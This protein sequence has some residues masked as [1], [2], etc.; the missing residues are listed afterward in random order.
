MPVTPNQ[1]YQK[2][3]ELPPLPLAMQKLCSIAGNTEVDADELVRVISMD[4][5]LTTK[6]LRVANSGHYGMGRESVTV[7]DVLMVL[8][9]KEIQ[10]VAIAMTLID[11]K[12]GV[13]GNCRLKRECLWQ[14]S[15]AVAS[16]MRLIAPL[17]GL[18]NPDEL[19]V[20]GLLHDIGKIIFSDYFAGQYNEVLER[21]AMGQRTLKAA[22]REAFGI[23]YAA[24]GHEVCCHWKLP[25][26]IRKMVDHQAIFIS[27][28]ASASVQEL[29][30]GAMEVANGLVRLARIGD[31]GDPVIGG[32]FF[33]VLQA[34]EIDFGDLR[35]FLPVIQE[36][37]RQAEK[38]LG[39]KGA[40][41]IPQ[42]PGPSAP[43]VG[44]LL[45][46]DRGREILKLALLGSGCLPNDNVEVVTEKI[47]LLA[48]L[49]D[50][51][52][53]EALIQS[54]EQF[55]VPTLNFALW[56]RENNPSGRTSQFDH[57]RLGEWLDKS[58]A[59]IKA[60]KAAVQ[61]SPPPAVP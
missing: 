42:S 29:T 28:K 43:M 23:N 32:D 56:H 57:V 15:L 17:F 14:H 30:A 27:D 45:K 6:L 54:C 47:P 7:S 24:L 10:N 4:E 55:Q 48:M 61:E 60:K 39:L 53:P 2:V 35:E 18:P 52:P 8:G 25:P 20:G 21:T 26:A 40:M 5:G 50:D 46:N 3:Q 37:A 13:E 51:Q 58:F 36:E 34:L 49:I 1:I 19:Y 44:I 41:P 12:T 9:L 11:F 59:E 33:Q 38:F 22:E 16:S 31:D